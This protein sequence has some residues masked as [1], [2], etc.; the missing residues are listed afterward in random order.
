MPVGAGTVGLEAGDD[1][2]GEV[3]F[4][5]ERAH[6]GAHRVGGD[7]GDIAEQAAAI[8]TVRAMPLGDGEHHLPVRHSREQR[9]VQPLCPEGEP[10][11]VAARADV[12]TRAREGEQGPVGVA[13]AP[14]A[15]EAMLSECGLRAPS[16]ESAATGASG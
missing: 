16:H 7:T 6:G 11:G 8:P 14:D 2:D 4:A 3:A 1:P 12:P 9:G 15:R 10:P 13:V 5:G